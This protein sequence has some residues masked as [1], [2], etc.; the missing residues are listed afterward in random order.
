M[1]NPSYPKYEDPSV[2]PNPLTEA[3]LLRNLVSH[4]QPVIQRDELNKYCD[5]LGI[6]REFHDPTDKDVINAIKKRKKIVK[7]EAKKIILNS[8]S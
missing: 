7:E 5:F 2:D 1:S 4:R 6:P 8:L 3:R